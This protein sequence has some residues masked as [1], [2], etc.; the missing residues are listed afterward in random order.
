[1]KRIFI[2]SS[3]LIVLVS[4]QNNKEELGFLVAK[5]EKI[6]EFYQNS[7][8]Q[9]YHS[10]SN[11]TDTLRNFNKKYFKP[12]DDF[13]KINEDCK[14]LFPLINNIKAEDNA[15]SV[16]NIFMF[17]PENYAKDYPVYNK[18]EMLRKNNKK[19]EYDINNLFKISKNRNISEELFNSELKK[20]LAKYRYN[21]IVEFAGHIGESNFK[22]YNHFVVAE[23][24]YKNYQKND[25]IKLSVFQVFDKFEYDRR[26]HSYF[27]LNDKTIETDNYKISFY[28]TSPKIKGEYVRMSYDSLRVSYPFYKELD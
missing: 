25:T 11:S 19:L 16:I 17:K 5:N 7:S 23:T 13:Y 3:L 12:I 26:N 27:K 20:I 28:S 21:V 4:C 6:T 22:F 2:I 9:L 1:M 24:D 18:P 15:D 14:N 10:V 8:E